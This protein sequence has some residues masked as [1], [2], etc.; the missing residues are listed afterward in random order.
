MNAHILRDAMAMQ[1]QNDQNI[2]SYVYA[3]AQ[4]KWDELVIFVK[5][6]PPLLKPI[7][8]KL[9]LEQLLQ[10]LGLNAWNVGNVF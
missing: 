10:V 8:I 4:C 3:K 6:C 9:T 1:R 5:Q 2:T 7:L